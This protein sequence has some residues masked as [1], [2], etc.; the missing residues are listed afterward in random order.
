MARLEWGPLAWGLRTPGPPLAGQHSP[1]FWA[2]QEFGEH[3]FPHHSPRT[4]AP[5]FTW[6]RLEPA[7]GPEAREPGTKAHSGT[8]YWRALM[9]PRAPCVTVASP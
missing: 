4:R 8:R 5:R 1:G 2:R 9:A 3:W 7:I 6:P